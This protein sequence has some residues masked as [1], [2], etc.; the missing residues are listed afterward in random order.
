MLLCV[1]D[2][3]LARII[4]RAAT[5]MAAWELVHAE[6]DAVH[7]LRHPLQLLVT[8]LTDVLQGASEPYGVY[9]E[10][11]LEV[12]EKLHDTHFDATEQSAANGLVRGRRDSAEKGSLVI[13]QTQ[14][15][16]AGFSQVIRAEVRGDA[17]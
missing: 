3:M 1:N 11:V 16:P 12:L 14:H 8:E 5:T 6:Y 9:D 4:H 10:R 7:E 2:K 13:P 15:V 17:Q